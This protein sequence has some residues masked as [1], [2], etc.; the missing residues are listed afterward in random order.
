MFLLVVSA[1]GA[2]YEMVHRSDTTAMKEE[3]AT[4]SDLDTS[5]QPPT[6]PPGS[7]GLE[8]AA[9]AYA[10]NEARLY[11]ENSKLAKQVEQ[12]RQWVDDLHSGMYVNCIYCGHRYGPAD[13]TP[14]S[15]ADALKEHI[16]SCP[17]HPMA[18]LKIELELVRTELA[19]CRNELAGTLSEMARLA[20]LVAAHEGG[21]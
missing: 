4:M 18:A 21:G 2:I 6:P 3:G 19:N 14:A 20:A 16:E 12:L 5:M 11:K 1:A 9:D 10:R 17:D 7:F 15:R 13:I 8:A